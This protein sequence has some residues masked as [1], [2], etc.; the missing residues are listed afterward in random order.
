MENRSLTNV[1]HSD[2]GGSFEIS[3]VEL[4]PWHFCHNTS[5][6]AFHQ[7]LLHIGV[8]NAYFGIN[9]DVFWTSDLPEHHLSLIDPTF[10]VC[11]CPSDDV[12]N[13][14]LVYIKASTSVKGSAANEDG[15]VGFGVDLHHLVVLWMRMELLVL[16]W[17]FITCVFAVLDVRSSFVA[18]CETLSVLSC[19]PVCERI[20]MSVKA[21]SSSCSHMVHRIPFFSLPSFFHHEPVNCQEEQEWWK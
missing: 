6:P 18:A 12:Y 3:P 17:I 5:S 11:I 10:Y 19:I 13:T 1:L 20:S 15:V 8:K 9:W 14:T 4:T 7:H 2:I 16:E 21:R